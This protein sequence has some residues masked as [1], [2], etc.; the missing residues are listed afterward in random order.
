[1]RNCG[2]HSN[3]FQQLVRTPAARVARGLCV[4]NRVLRQQSAGNINL[5]T[6][7]YNR[8]TAGAT[9]N[10]ASRAKPPVFNASRR[11]ESKWKMRARE[12]TPGKIF[13]GAET[14]TVIPSTLQAFET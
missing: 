5:R 11:C 6:S 12:E 8:P 14:G 1:M 10:S 7:N 9:G 13:P 2:A 3:I 4:P